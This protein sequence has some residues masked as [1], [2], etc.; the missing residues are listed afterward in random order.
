MSIQGAF[1]NFIT[2]LTRDTG[3]DNP[4]KK[5]T[6]AEGAFARFMHEIHAQWKYVDR[7]SFDDARRVIFRGIEVNTE[8][9]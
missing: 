7:V 2:T 6:L 3:D 4:V 9:K 1:E 8:S 5:V